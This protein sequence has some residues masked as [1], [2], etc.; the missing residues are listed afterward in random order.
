MNLVVVERKKTATTTQ[1]DPFENS[2]CRVQGNEAA[3]QMYNSQH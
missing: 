2:L 3:P 1:I